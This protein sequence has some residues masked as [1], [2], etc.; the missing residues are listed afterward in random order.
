MGFI[1][2]LCDQHDELNQKIHAKTAV[3]VLQ[4]LKETTE[5]VTLVPLHEQILIDDFRTDSVPEEVI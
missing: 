5:V 4:S 1:N 2:G 3:P